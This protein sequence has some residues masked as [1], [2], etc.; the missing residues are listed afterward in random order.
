[1]LVV[2]PTVTCDIPRLRSAFGDLEIGSL[3]HDVASKRTARPF[4]T[5]DLA[6]LDGL[7]ISML[8]C[9]TQWQRAVTSGSPVL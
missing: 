8:R 2:L 4:L 3:G 7:K 9:L 6:N 5:I 1:M